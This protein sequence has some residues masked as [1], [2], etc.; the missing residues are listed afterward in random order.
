M[1]LPEFRERSPEEE[2]RDHWIAEHQTALM[3][4]YGH[5]FGMA[6]LLA[7]Y[8]WD[9]LQQMKPGPAILVAGI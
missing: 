6:H 3:L 9:M 7:A 1:D 4:D 8:S 5:D 2:A